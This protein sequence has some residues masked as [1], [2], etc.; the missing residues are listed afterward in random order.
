[1]DGRTALSLDPDTFR[2]AAAR[3]AIGSLGLV[4]SEAEDIIWHMLDFRLTEHPKVR[5]TA[6]RKD[7][8]QLSDHEKRALG[9]R[10]N[11]FLSRRAF[12]EITEVGMKFP[13]A[14]HEKVL[15]RASFSLFRYRTIQDT[16]KG[17]RLPDTYKYYV[18]N[19]ECPVCR[20]LDGK[21]TKGDDAYLFAV[22]GCQCE[23]ANYSLTNYVDWLA[24]ID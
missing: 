15:L 2:L 21:V 14:A 11:A 6:Y 19:M 7:G 18:L 10:S 24:Y 4:V 23:T 8:E 5:A 9:L 1:M 3:E 17:N 20:D 12:A 22:P 13:L 16:R